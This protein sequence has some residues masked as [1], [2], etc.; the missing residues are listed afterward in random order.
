MDE[1][2]ADKAW[3]LVGLTDDSGQQICVLDAGTY[4]I[5]TA[6]LLKWNR[7]DGQAGTF[8]QTRNF[9][10][11]IPCGSYARPSQ[12]ALTKLERARQFSYTRSIILA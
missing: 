4:G 10:T 11:E 2:T 12:R 3:G 5:R 6:D 1:A 8:A 7:I 9:T